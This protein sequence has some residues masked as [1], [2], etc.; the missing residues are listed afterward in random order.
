[1]KTKKAPEV[2]LP[3]RNQTASAGGL[4]K[5]TCRIPATPRGRVNWYKDGEIIRA[6]GRF[7]LLASKH[8]AYRLVIHGSQVTDSGKYSIVVQNKSGS[9]Q[10]QCDLIVI[11][12]NY[13]VTFAI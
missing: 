12:N 2:V 1:M 10:S 3:L 5:L 9:A 7:E 6:E 13:L 11:G 8:G 4:V